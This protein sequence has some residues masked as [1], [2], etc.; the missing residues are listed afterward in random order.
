MVCFDMPSS[1]AFKPALI[2]LN[3]RTSTSTDD[4]FAGVTPDNHAAWIWIPTLLGLS[5]AVCFLG[6]RAILKGRKFGADDA[7]LGVAY[8]SL[9]KALKLLAPPP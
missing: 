1:S 5:Y 4:R 7:V 2:L 3:S 6:F 9:P 8:V